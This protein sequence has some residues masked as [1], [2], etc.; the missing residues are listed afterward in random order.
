[1]KR[2]KKVLDVFNGSF[3]SDPVREGPL[4]F[5]F[6]LKKSLGNPALDSV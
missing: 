3:L 5:L 2:K 1:M 6:L 4:L